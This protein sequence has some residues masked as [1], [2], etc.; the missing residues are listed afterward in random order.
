MDTS[1]I[2]KTARHRR[3]RPRSQIAPSPE[4]KGNM[5]NDTTEVVSSRILGHMKFEVAALKGEPHDPYDRRDNV[6]ELE[7]AQREERTH[8]CQDATKNRNERLQRRAG[9]TDISLQ[10]LVRLRER[11]LETQRPHACA[12]R[13]VAATQTPA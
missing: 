3:V 9:S 6:H 12:T 7:S 4:A 2:R 10:L 8:I 1:A 11:D 13:E 5:L